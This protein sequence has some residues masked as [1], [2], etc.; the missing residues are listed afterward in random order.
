MNT[1]TSLWPFAVPPQ[2]LVPV[3]W[4][5][6]LA[7]AGC[8][9]AVAAAPERGACAASSIACVT[10]FLG[11]RGTSAR[12]TR[13][14]AADGSETLH[15]ETDLTF[16]AHARRCIVEDVSLDARG[17]LTQADVAVGDSCAGPADASAHLDPAGGVVRVTT[18]AGV[19]ER[20]APSASPW[21]YTPEVLPDRALTTPIAAWVAARAAALSPTVTLVQLERRQVWRV[22]S[23]QVVV[24]TELGSTVVLGDE[25]ADVEGGFVD[26][27]RMPDYAMTLVRTQ[28]GGEPR[29]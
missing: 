17:Q 22:P 10:T 9:A 8:D 29:S 27:I 25:G 3:A 12:V 21:V 15:G 13:S 2:R 24:A 5:S 1:T 11:E 16:G 28:R 7:L 6:A 14:R 19:V 4:F 26:R 18:P 20:R 23:D